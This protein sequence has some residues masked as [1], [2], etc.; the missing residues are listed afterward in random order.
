MIELRPCMANQ[1]GPDGPIPVQVQWLVMAGLPYMDR[2]RHVGYI[3]LHD[4][5]PFNGLDLFRTLSPPL[6]EQLIAE[7]ETALQSKIEKVS[8][9]PA[10]VVLTEEDFE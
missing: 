4:G 9:P 2:L 5:A 10:P 8:M 1:S 3:G 7:V 6:R